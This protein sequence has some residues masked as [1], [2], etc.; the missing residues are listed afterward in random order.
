MSAINN[1]HITHLIIMSISAV[2]SAASSSR[3]AFVLGSES[4]GTR[5]VAEEEDQHVEILIVS[6]ARRRHRTVDGLE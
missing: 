4:K 2:L 6:C 1:H 5:L 3:L